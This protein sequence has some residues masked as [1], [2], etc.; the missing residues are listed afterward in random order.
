MRKS[1]LVLLLILMQ[2]CYPPSTSPKAIEFNHS[3]LV[4]RLA[5]PAEI[6]ELLDQES[7][8][9]FHHLSGDAGQVFALARLSESSQYVLFIYPCDSIDPE[10]S[11]FILSGE[12]RIKTGKIDHY[13][14]KLSLRHTGSVDEKIGVRFDLPKQSSCE[15]R[16]VAIGNSNAVYDMRAEFKNSKWVSSLTLG[17]GGD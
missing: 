16:L 1:T 14:I 6:G 17:L 8:I 7:Q 15:I 10:Q 4:Q 3:Q 13:T 11:K 9:V 12:D 5:S 2:G